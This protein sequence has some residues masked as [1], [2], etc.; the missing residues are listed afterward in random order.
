MKSARS[1]ATLGR[2]E[3]PEIETQPADAQTSTATGSPQPGAATAIQ[4]LEAPDEEPP[5]A[6]RSAAKA[7]R[8]LVADDSAEVRD[9]LARSLHEAGYEVL[10]AADGQEALEKFAPGL[11]DLVL[12]DLEMPVM[13]GWNAFEELVARDANQGIILLSDQLGQ[14]DLTTT[15]HFAR[16]AEK[17]I[18][19]RTLLALIEDVL[20]ETAPHRTSAVATQKNLARFAKPYTGRFGPPASYEHW[21]IND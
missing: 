14:V 9:L 15:G 13:N 5:R 1:V 8:I 3:S 20:G 18:N 11:V 4:H 12:L 19:L 21:G 2:P 7:M 10:L 6:A 17:P 16:L